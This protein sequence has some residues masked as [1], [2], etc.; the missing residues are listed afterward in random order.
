MST[1]SHRV[2]STLLA[3]TFLVGR[4]RLEV[5]W[6]DFCDFVKCC[7]RV[8]CVCRNARMSCNS[9]CTTL[10]GG[11][12]E[13]WVAQ[14]RFLPW[15]FLRSPGRDDLLAARG[16]LGGHAP[17]RVR[18]QGPCL[19][20]LP[21]ALSTLTARRRTC[22]P[23]TPRLVTRPPAHASVHTAPKVQAGPLL[24]CAGIHP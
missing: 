12:S 20:S 10:R 24:S 9:V 19:A 11:G 14:S 7:V 6:S 1:V 17:L 18:G 2:P 22:I 5:K 8:W 3:N 13:I 15:W 4:H 21:R 16:R 23:H